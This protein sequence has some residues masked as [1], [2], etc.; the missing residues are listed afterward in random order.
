MSK[1]TSYGLASDYMKELKMWGNTLNAEDIEQVWR[2]PPDRKA[3]HRL[4]MTLFKLEIL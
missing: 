1:Y 3:F 4:V 2:L